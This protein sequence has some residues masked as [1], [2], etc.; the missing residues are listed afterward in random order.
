MN[1][2]GYVFPLILMLA[3]GGYSVWTMQKRQKAMGSLGPAMQSFFQSTGFRYADMPPDPVEMHA[4]RAM[5]EANTHQMGSR[6]THYVRNFHGLAIH[7]KQAYI[8]DESG[9]SISCSWSADLPGPPRIPFHIADKS[10]GS[11]GKAVREVFSNSTR[12]WSPKHPQPVQTGIP[13]I[14]QRFNVFGQD[15]N[16]VRYLFQ[17]NPAL[18]AALLQQV[19]VDVWIDGSA[20]VFADPMQKNMN[21]AMGGMVGQMALGFDIAKRME[22]SVPVHERISELLALA[23]RAATS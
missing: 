16:A 5:Q 14:D 10:L 15:P 19:E 11:M 12:V 20:A 4:Q 18:V 2:A 3:F 22:M 21:A 23:V 6:V 8:V 1:Y 17:Q 7:H 13:Q 9:Y